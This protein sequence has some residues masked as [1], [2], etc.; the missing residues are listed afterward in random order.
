M[1]AEGVEFRG[2][3]REK[4]TRLRKV[5][6]LRPREL[7][8]VTVG[9]ERKPSTAGGKSPGGKTCRSQPS[10]IM[11]MSLR[12]A[13]AAVQQFSYLSLYDIL[14]L[15]CNDLEL[16]PKRNNCYQILHAPSK[17]AQNTYTFLLQ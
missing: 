14:Q 4:G 10:N 1:P 5:H 6:E 7:L 8:V 16:Q 13:L 2:W 12:Q 3:G 15:P 17:Q 11:S 9:R